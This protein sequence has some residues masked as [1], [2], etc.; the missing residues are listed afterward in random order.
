MLLYIDIAYLIM[1]DKPR[2]EYPNIEVR[3]HVG[4]GTD[5]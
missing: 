5:G 4:D 3:L 2:E 1:K